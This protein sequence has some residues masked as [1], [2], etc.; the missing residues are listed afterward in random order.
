MKTQLCRKVT[1]IEFEGID[2]NDLPDFCDAH[3][4]SCDLNGNPATDD[5][6]DEL[7]NDSEFVYRSLINFLY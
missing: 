6:L 1:N 2:Y 5:E 3:I 7:N 4:V